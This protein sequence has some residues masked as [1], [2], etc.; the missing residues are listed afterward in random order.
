[1]IRKLFI[2]LMSLISIPVWGQQRDAKDI[3]KL[4]KNLSDLEA[5]QNSSEFQEGNFC[6]TF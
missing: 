1:M 5:Y 2:V 3:E 4:F 6:K